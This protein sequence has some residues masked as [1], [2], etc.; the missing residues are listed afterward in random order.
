[1][2]L[3][4]VLGCAAAAPAGAAPDAGTESNLALGAGSRAIALGGAC[5]AR[6]GDASA[7][8]WNP[9]GLAG[10]ERGD[11]AAMHARIGFG[12]AGQTFVGLAYPTLRAG[13]FGLGML[14]L[15]SG[16]I[17]AFDAG[18]NAL[19][20][21][22]YAETALYASWAVRPRLPGLER[23]LSLG[24]TA[25]SVTQS[26]T[27]WSSTGAGLDVGMVLEPPGLPQLALAVVVQD[28][29]APRLRL[30]EE[31]DVVPATLRLAGSLRLAL[32]RDLALDLHAGMDRPGALG[33]TPRLGVE[34]E[35]RHRLLLRLGASRHGSAL[36]VGLRWGHFGLDYAYLTRSEAVTHPVSLSAGWGSSRLERRTALEARQQSRRQ[37][38]LRAHLQQMIEARHA[39][40]Q[41]A[42]ER[43]DYAAAL[44]EWKIVAGLDPSDERA[45]R[46]M[47]AAGTQLAALQSRSRQDQS[48]AA[49][50]A[51]QFALGLR[52]YGSNDYVLAR[53][54]WQQLL[55]EEPDNAEA[56]RYLRKTQERLLEQVRHHAEQARALE[57][58]GDFVSAL[59]AWN[60]VRSVDAL[61]PE[62]EPALRRCRAALEG[63][64]ARR[65][66]VPQQPSRAAQASSRYNEALGLY[67]A[68]EVERAAGVLRE[69]LKL[70]R[71]NSAAAELLARAERQLRPL[72]AE[73]KARVRDLYLR[74]M[75]WFTANEFEKAIAE[76]SKILALD[77]GNASVY[78]NIDEA[79][80]RLRAMQN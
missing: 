4:L 48:Q 47:Q 20:D 15:S 5:L 80:A 25:K 34:C 12:A 1:M 74:G 19:G 33:W 78:Q 35:Y 11:L 79:R 28:A 7:M 43:G 61:H 59:A 75:S 21:I 49:A 72:S 57:A 3:A 65:R 64:N 52:Y 60:Q 63:A 8:F 16:D 9:A 70:D 38:E 13:S 29:L 6:V 27:P 32:H 71:D 76:W 58:R 77:P 69:V 36:G 54:V 51:A 18:S 31:A 46:G 42:Y 67:S 68:G 22:E 40:A 2:L 26:L 55:A 17:Q 30:D 10:L 37:E 23:G 14:R 73:D 45:G 66:S 41:A 50:R 44:D 56:R 62:A 39:G 53:N 24:I